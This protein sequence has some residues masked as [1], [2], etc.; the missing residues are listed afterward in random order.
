MKFLNEFKEFITK[1]NIIDLAVAVVIGSSF[2]S[3]ISSLVSDVIT[4][5]LLTPALNAAHVE[6]LDKLSW[7]NVK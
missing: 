6:G 3:I 2:G 4:P 1:G 7:R 5:L